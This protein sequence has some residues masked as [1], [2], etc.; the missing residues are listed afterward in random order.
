[1]DTMNSIFQEQT[2]TSA[3]YKNDDIKNTPGMLAY[4]SVSELLID[5]SY[6]RLVNRS[7]VNNIAGMWDWRK[8]KCLNVAYRKD[9]GAYFVYD[10][11]HTALAAKQL[12]IESLPCYIINSD[13]VKDEA[14]GFV[15]INRDR[16]VVTSAGQ[17]KAMVQAEDDRAVR[18]KSILNRHGIRLSEGKTYTENSTQAIGS[19]LKIMEFGG[20]DN[21]L[22]LVLDFVIKT[23]DGKPPSLT[24]M[25]LT[26]L[27]SFLSRAGKS[28]ERSELIYSLKRHTAEEIY[29]RVKQLSRAKA[30]QCG[31]TDIWRDV[32]LECYNHKKRNRLVLD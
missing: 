8:V 9:K 14:I 27:W 20:A 1:M 15:G 22:D 23:W 29:D 6:Q 4:I 11:Q 28:V 3:H 26:G 18:L 32:F 7:H 25:F 10:G 5:E 21:N 30:R 17:I 16:R 12:G 19:L 31:T 2:L 24:G 13:S